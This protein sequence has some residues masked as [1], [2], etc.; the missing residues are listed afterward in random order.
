M[1]NSGHCV[2]S[3]QKCRVRAEPQIMDLFQHIRLFAP[4]SFMV[5]YKNEE[6]IR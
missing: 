3:K 6:E 5:T 4:A 2:G 1:Y